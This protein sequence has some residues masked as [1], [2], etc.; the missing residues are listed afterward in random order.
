MRIELELSEDTVKFLT[1]VSRHN[2]ESVESLID[3]WLREN[4]EYEAEK[5]ASAA[6]LRGR[7]E[8]AKAGHT[9]DAHEAI[10]RTAERHGI[11]LNSQ[12]EVT[13]G[14]R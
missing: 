11:K 10:Q 5:L 6:M 4:L 12:R 1:E 2:G 13:A 8:R 7:V 9:V 3:R 14:E